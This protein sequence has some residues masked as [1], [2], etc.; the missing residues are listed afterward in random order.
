M[1]TVRDDLVVSVDY[2]LRLADGE[3][4]DSSV[5][6]A[7]LTFIQGRGEVIPGLE[8]ALYGMS[9]GEEKDVVVA[10]ADA[11]GEFDADLLKTLPRSVFPPDMILEEGQGFRLRTN[12]GQ[13]VV[14]YVYA[15]EDDQVTL[16][17]NHPLAGETLY[18]N[19]KIAGL[20]EATA[21]ELDNSLRPS[22]CSGCASAQE[23]CGDEG[24]CCQ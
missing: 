8:K 18:F 10:P 3:I 24:D 13:V 2:T 19:V 9:V 7:P 14:A 12:S 16:D 6:R 5:G 21:E 15:V 4:V 20:R 23:G 11:Y 22:G 17:L 1:L